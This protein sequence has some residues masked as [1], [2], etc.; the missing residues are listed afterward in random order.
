MNAFQIIVLLFGLVSVG[1]AGWA[2]VAIYRSTVLKWKWLW[3][4]G[5]LVGFVG[6]GINWTKPDDIFLEFG[7]QIP[8]WQVVYFAQSHEVTVKIM[9]PIIAVIALFESQPQALPPQNSSD[10]LPKSD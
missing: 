3:I 2:I 5:S 8:V 6:L 4:V 10:A 9:F 1:I 7:I